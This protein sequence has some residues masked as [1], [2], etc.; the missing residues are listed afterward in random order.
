MR[1]TGLEQLRCR[2][3]LIALIG[4]LADA[5]ML[6]CSLTGEHAIAVF[7]IGGDYGA[8]IR[9]EFLADLITDKTAFCL[10]CFAH[11][12]QECVIFIARKTA[13]SVPCNNL[14]GDGFI[15]LRSC[16]I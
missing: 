12:Q 16:R 5:L 6:G 8:N 10:G 1:L 9:H 7:H 14:R 15:T 4:T 2:I 3:S 11:L 13:G